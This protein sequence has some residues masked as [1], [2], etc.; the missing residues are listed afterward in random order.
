MG[1]KFKVFEMQ[2]WN[3]SRYRAQKVDEK[4]DI[5]RLVMFTSKVMVFRI[6][7]I[8]HLMYFLPNTEKKQSQ[9]G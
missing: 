3:I 6:S 8:A 2:K 5:I 4:N 7:K 1:L 9:F